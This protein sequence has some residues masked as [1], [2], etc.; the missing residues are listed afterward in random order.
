VTFTLTSD[1][2][3]DARARYDP[4]PAGAELTLCFDEPFACWD[5]T[6]TNFT[7]ASRSLVL[8]ELAHA[9]MDA[10]LA[11]SVRQRFIDHAGLEVWS[12]HSYPW[13]ERAVEHAADAVAWGLLDRDML[14]YRTGSPNP[15]HLATG[16]RILTGTEP[17]PKTD[18][19]AP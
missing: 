1:L 12:D 17:L 2:C 13:I 10:G 8:H 9:W 14:M 4:T 19:Y 16:F 11:E 15:D 3:D 5:D 18:E 7:P 6:C